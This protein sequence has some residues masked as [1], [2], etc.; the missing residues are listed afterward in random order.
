MSK[1]LS[2]SERSIIEHGLA[3][4]KTFAS[5]SRLLDRSPSTISREVLNYRAFVNKEAPNSP[6]DCVYYYTCT[7]HRICHSAP[8]YACMDRCKLCPAIQIQFI[9][10]TL[11]LHITSHF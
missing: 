9:N 3:N 1:H 10:K 11:V 7:R 2:F 8:T 5:I 6:R 4:D